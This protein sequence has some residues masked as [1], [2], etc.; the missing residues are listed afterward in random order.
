[1]T[2]FQS[3]NP[4]LVMLLT[5]WFV[6]HWTRL[7]RNDNEPS[8]IDKMSAG[9]ALIAASYLVLAAAA[10][11][12][13]AHGTQSSWPWLLAFLAVMTIGE[14]YVLPIGLGLFGR[15]APKGFAG[16][17]IAVWYFAG[18]VGNLLAGAVG[19]LWSRLTP[20]AF[21]VMTAAIAACA[22]ALL[23]LFNGAVTRAEI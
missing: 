9:M 1:M 3:L 23:R 14:L 6:M 21:F 19:T 11:W 20:G 7:A 15:L 16:T 13:Q 4:L 10:A 17:A 12:A 22:A 5:P 2:W 18:F 8:S